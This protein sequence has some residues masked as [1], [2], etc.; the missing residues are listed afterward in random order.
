MRLLYLNPLNYII[1]IWNKIIFHLVN[2]NVKNKLQ[3]SI[4]R[5]NLGEASNAFDNFIIPRGISLI[6]VIAEQ[7]QVIR[8][9][10]YIPLYQG[11]QLSR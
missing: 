6:E 11:E 2:H 1:I 9:Q 4:N 8:E 5:N 3:Y 10:K 7:R